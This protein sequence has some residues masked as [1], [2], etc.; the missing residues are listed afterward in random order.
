[1]N[2]KQ[3]FVQMTSEMKIVTSLNLKNVLKPKLSTVK[4]RNLIEQKKIKNF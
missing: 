4:S 2:H 3:W 1:M